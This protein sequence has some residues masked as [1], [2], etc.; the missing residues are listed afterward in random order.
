[1]SLLTIWKERNRSF[2]N[3]ELSVLRLKNLFLCYLFSQA[4]MYI[5][6]GS[7]SLCDFIDW[8]DPH[9]GKE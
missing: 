9:Y 4:K 8:L 5:V 7:M 6:V 1:M 2:E 3:K